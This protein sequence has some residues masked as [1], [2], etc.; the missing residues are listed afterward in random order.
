MAVDGLDTVHGTLYICFVF[1]N[2]GSHVKKKMLVDERLLYLVSS[3]HTS[4]KNA[5]IYKAR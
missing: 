1:E 2:E 5:L 3:E 4:G